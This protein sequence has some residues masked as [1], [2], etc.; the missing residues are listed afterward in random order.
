MVRFFNHL[1]IYI[2]FHETNNELLSYELKTF[3]NGIE[4]HLQI[5]FQG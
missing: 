2:I 5:I 3:R 4:H 1:L